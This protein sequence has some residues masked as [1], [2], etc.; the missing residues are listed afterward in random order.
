MAKSDLFWLPDA[1]TNRC[2]STDEKVH[3]E[4]SQTGLASLTL[5]HKL[6]KKK[7]RYNTYPNIGKHSQTQKTYTKQIRKN[8]HRNRKVEI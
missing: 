7:Y 2:T 4:T 8:K 6:N 1:L 3:S 5:K